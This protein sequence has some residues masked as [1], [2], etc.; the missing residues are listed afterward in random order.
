[1]CLF[2]L[3]AHDSPL[4]GFRI[5]N[6]E[7]RGRRFELIMRVYIADD[8]A[9]VRDALRL[10]LT[11][12]HDLQVVGE[13]DDAR[14]LLREA[15]KLRPDLILLDWELPGLSETHP[16]ESLRKAAPAA[17]VIALSGQSDKSAVALREGAFAFVSKTDP[18]E[19]LLAALYSAQKPHDTNTKPD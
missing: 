12:E 7:F 16:L 10:L 9:R 14:L 8:Q 17:K 18:P 1:M 5:Q 19:V 11:Q 6:G 4:S 2:A 15:K 13:A 3:H